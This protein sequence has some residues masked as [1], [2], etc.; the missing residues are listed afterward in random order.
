MDQPYK[1]RDESRERLKKAILALHLKKN[2][3][4][5][6]NHAD[7]Q[8][9]IKQV[10]RELERQHNESTNDGMKGVTRDDSTNKLIMLCSNVAITWQAVIAA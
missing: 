5:N 6:Y 4:G 10:G 9:F 7:A 2:D 1:V 3:S 8:I